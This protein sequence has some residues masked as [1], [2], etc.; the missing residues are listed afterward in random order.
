MH[1]L[2]KSWRFRCSSTQLRTAIELNIMRFVY[3][4]P[5]ATRICGTTRY[6][7]LRR[8]IVCTRVLCAFLN[9]TCVR[10]AAAAALKPD[11]DE[12]CDDVYNETRIV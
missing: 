4:S 7:T 1:K 8:I 12:I 3:F 2:L 9:N 6:C 10:T 5:P 11:V